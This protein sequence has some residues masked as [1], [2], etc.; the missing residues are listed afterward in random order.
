MEFS[1]G[2]LRVSLKDDVNDIKGRGFQKWVANLSKI[3]EHW[4]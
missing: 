3:W 4:R 2:L 1:Y